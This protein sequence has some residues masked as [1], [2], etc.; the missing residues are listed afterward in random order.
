MAASG[1][2]SP[3]FLSF[4]GGA[5][6]LLCGSLSVLLSSITNFKRITEHTG[7]ELTFDP[8][9]KKKIQNSKKKTLLFTNGF[10]FPHFRMVTR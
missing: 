6:E 4:T 7:F 10:L 9:L 8:D 5:T 1:Q 3:G 2:A